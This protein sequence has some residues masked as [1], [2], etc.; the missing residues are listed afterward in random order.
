MWEELQARYSILCIKEIIESGKHSIAVKQEVHDDYN[1]R[2]DEALKSQIWM[3]MS[4][5]SY[6]RNEFERVDVNMPWMPGE[7]MQWALKPDLK[8][9][10]LK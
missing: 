4:Q 7:F 9:F 5:K 2:M 8:D 1:E 6:Y 3:D 10:E